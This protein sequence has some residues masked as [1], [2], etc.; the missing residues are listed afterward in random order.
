MEGELYLIGSVI[1]WYT[2]GGGLFY[3]YFYL[4]DFQN[5][6]IYYDMAFINKGYE[7]CKGY[8]IIGYVC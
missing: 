8:L 2:G 3:W 4:I 5:L 1:V 6:F 7:I